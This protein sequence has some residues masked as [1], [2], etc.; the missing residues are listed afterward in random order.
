MKPLSL[1]VKLAIAFVAVA[2]VGVTLVAILANRVTT[3]GFARYLSAEQQAEYTSLQRDLT[4][5]YATNGSWD[6]VA[7]LFDSATAGRGQGPGRGQGTA[8]G[9]GQGAAGR[10]F[11]L[12]DAAGNE[13]YTNAGRGQRQ[14]TWDP[15]LILPLVVNGQ[16]VGTLEV[17]LAGPGSQAAEQYLQSVNNALL[18]AGV[19]AVA[20][21]LALAVVLARYLTRPLRQLN[22]ATQ[23]MAAGDLS[24]RVL[25]RQRDE[26]GELAGS[27]NQM[28][29]ALDSAE[30]QRQQLLADTAHDLRTP[31]SVI[32]SHLEAM[33]DGVFPPTPQNLG[34]IH[35][36]TVLLNRLVNDVRTLSLA[37]SGQLP[38]DLAPLD[39]GV[40]AEQAVN[41][42]QPLAEA[43]GVSLSLDRSPV[44]L[45]DADAARVQ[46]LFAN[47]L[48]NALRHAP[49]G[50][51]E[52]PAVQVRVGEANGAVRVEIADNGPG[53]SAE[54]QQHVF[55][56]F[57]RSD[58]ARNRN[59]GG[60]GLGLAITRGVIAAHGGDITV[61]SDPGHGATFAF[62]LPLAD[63]E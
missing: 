50:A 47:L 8:Q 44:G 60:S 21:A 14:T 57:W 31:I 49:Q 9:A 5:F 54:Q 45:V 29:E 15:D 30:K 48:A 18:W 11:I 13:V 4:A 12:R 24:Q 23:Q 51:T 25:V 58:Q 1:T 2:L 63:L 34:V 59:D 36:E 32:Q 16:S 22:T 26:L 61:V 20:V 35:E 38:L 46:Q 27:F 40:A 39:L 28:A 56:R 19:L 3:E 37:E 10:F 52:Q 62:T 53:L 33:L 42:F 17:A 6:G 55:D 7:A 43:D 41:A